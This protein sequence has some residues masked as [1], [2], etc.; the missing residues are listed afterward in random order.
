MATTKRKP[1]EWCGR[2][3]VPK[4][5]TR[6]FCGSGHALDAARARSLP[7]AEAQRLQDAARTMASARRAK[8]AGQLRANLAKRPHSQ[9]EREED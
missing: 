9:R 6:L 2:L 1:C 4:F 5:P 3:F 8:Y 7:P